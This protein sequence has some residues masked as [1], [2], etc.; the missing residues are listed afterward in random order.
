MTCV[1]LLLS[2]IGYLRMLLQRI[3]FTILL[4]LKL[5]IITTVQYTK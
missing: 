5:V 4:N 3:I 1:C 2:Y